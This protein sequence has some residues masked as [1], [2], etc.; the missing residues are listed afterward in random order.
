MNR[1]HAFVAAD[2]DELAACKFCGETEQLYPGF[3][4][5]DMSFSIDVHCLGCGVLVTPPQGVDAREFW[6][7]S[8]SDSA[9]QEKEPKN[10]E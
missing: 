7:R 9:V 10:A 4:M 5:A 8:A 3:N 2:V 6:N 1:E